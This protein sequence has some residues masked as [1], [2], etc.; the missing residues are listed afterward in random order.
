MKMVLCV[1]VTKP[2]KRGKER[3]DRESKD[4]NMQVS[5]PGYQM[6]ANSINLLPSK[7]MRSKIVLIP[8]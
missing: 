8:L 4:N 5:R 3:R 2:D 6:V 1:R 7:Q